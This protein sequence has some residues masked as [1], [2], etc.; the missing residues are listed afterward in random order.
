MISASVGRRCKNNTYDVKTVQVLLNLNMNRLS[1]LTAIRQDGRLDTATITAI[2]AFQAR[3]MSVAKP[4]G[5]VDPTGATLRQL[6]EGMTGGFSEA[7]LQGI[8][9]RADAHA[10]KTYYPVLNQKMSQYGINTPLRMAHFLAQIAHESQ[11]LARTEELASGEAYEGRVDLGNTQPG[12]GR[13]FKDRGLIQLT[14]R[15]NYEAYGKARDADYTTDDKV[16]LIGIDPYLAADAACWFWTVKKHATAKQ[17]ANSLADVDDL[18]G[19]T[20]TINGGYNGLEDRRRV[21][22]RAKFFLIR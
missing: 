2:E 22:E 19:V 5:R 13:Q 8:M 9:I 18:R 14:G 12:D 16:W 20:Y 3:V 7:K 17:S 4:D 15:A 10:V 11:Q 1:P 6:R 21:L